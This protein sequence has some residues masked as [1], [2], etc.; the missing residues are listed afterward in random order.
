LADILKEMFP[1]D[2][3]KYEQILQ[4]AQADGQF[5][6]LATALLQMV[7]G[8]VEK[9]ALHNDPEVQQAIPQ[10]QQIKQQLGSQ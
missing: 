8:L 7:E 1:T 5:R 2:G 4:Q 6:Q 10:L 3:V 9:P